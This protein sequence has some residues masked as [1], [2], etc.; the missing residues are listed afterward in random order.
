MLTAAPFRLGRR[1]WRCMRSGDF[2]PSW[3]GRFRLRPTIYESVADIL[4]SSESR[5]RL[6]IVDARLIVL[7][8]A[9]TATMT[10]IFVR[11][12][13]SAATLLLA[14]AYT[15]NLLLL[16]QLLG[17]TTATLHAILVQVGTTSP[18]RDDIIRIIHIY[19][20]II[21]IV[22]FVHDKIL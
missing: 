18:P 12:S 19:I 7:V 22:A 9:V 11:S 3:R 5:A 14:T 8:A 16:V 20:Y 2:W 21:Y 13:V 1:R 6:T 17:T 15:S 4:D 10:T